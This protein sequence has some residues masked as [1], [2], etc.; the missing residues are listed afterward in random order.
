MGLWEPTIKDKPHTCNI[1]HC[2]EGRMITLPGEYQGI[3]IWRISQITPL[4][5]MIERF[6]LEMKT[7]IE[8]QVKPCIEVI[9]LRNKMVGLH[10][11]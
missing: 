3:H 5:C 9:P 11:S 1:Q 10:D 2:E 6:S 4:F 8:K 7:K